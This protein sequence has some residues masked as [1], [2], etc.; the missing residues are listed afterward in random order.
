MKVSLI[1][2]TYNWEE[3]LELV[4]KSVLRQN[5]LPDE[6]I[7]A[8]DGSGNKTKSLINEYKKLFPVPL[9]HIW[10]EDNGFRLS[11]I[12]NKAIEKAQYEYIIQIDGDV[13][14]HPKFIEDHKKYACKNCFVTGSRVMLGAKT[15]EKI[16]ENKS[17]L[18]SFI[19]RENSNKFNGI[20]FPLFNNLFSHPKNKP[21]ERLIVR[22]RGCN[23]AFWRE[24]LIAVNGYDE[25]FVGWGREDSEIV[26]RLIKKGVY[27]KKIKFAAIQYHLYHKTSS[28]DNLKTNEEILQK[29][30]LSNS[31]RVKNGILKIN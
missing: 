8:D 9:H 4:L 31:F 17:L 27:R 21:I 13:I 6:V 2:T 15:T 7:V 22:V 11:A 12:R 1:I 14:L 19:N 5:I 29:A 26:T 18:F 30:L 3:A 20:Y 24:D 28:K 23:M 16:I 10:H 25:N